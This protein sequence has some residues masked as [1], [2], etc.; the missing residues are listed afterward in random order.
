MPAGVDRP[1]LSITAVYHQSP[2]RMKSHGSAA[3]AA[4]LLHTGS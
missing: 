4:T 3:V 1:L 2:A